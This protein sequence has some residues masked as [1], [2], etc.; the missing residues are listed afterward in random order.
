M[1]IKGI[2]SWTIGRQG[3]IGYPPLI[4]KVG[5]KWFWVEESELHG[6][7]ICQKCS[8]KYAQKMQCIA[9]VVPRLRKEKPKIGKWSYIT[10]DEFE[11]LV[12][13]QFNQELKS[14]GLNLNNEEPEKERR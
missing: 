4:I 2:I 12:K 8:K 7:S 5:R 3:G 1:K 14:L 11:S 6:G 10:W 13:K 9:E